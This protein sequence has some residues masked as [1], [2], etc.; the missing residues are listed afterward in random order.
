MGSLEIRVRYCECDP[1][2]LAH[3]SA[4]PVWF[5]M[6]RTELCRGEGIAYRDL[7]ESGFFLA[8]VRLEVQYRAPA[9]YDDVLALETTLERA[10]RAKLVHTYRLLREGRLLAVGKTT[11]AC[12]D[13]DGRPQAL[14]EFLRAGS[15]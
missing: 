7:E 13:R 11:L 3:H 2:G 9:R 6:G 1:M 12:L 15:E 4:Y 10:T 14:P 5:E 8:V